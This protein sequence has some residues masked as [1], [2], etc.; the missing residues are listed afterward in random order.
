[1]KEEDLEKRI[2]RIEDVLVSFRPEFK[3]DFCDHLPELVQF[4]EDFDGQSTGGLVWRKSSDYRCQKCGIFLDVNGN[5][6]IK[7][8]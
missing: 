4:R 6:P 7:R 1:M 3:Y 5:V 2:K 8:A